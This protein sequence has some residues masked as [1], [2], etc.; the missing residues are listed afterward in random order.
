MDFLP[1]DVLQCICREWIGTNNIRD[2]VALDRAICKKSLRQKFLLSISS[3]P[4]SYRSLLFVPFTG[5]ILK[6][7]FQIFLKWMKVRGVVLDTL[8]LDEFVKEIPWTTLTRIKS[9]SLA[10]NQN[11]VNMLVILDNLPYLEDLQL[12]GE[13]KL[14]HI[15]W[16]N[17]SKPQREVLLLTKLFLNLDVMECEQMKNIFEYLGLHAKKLTKV[18]LF[19]NNEHA[20]E[21]LYC[22]QYITTLV[23]LD[24]MNAFEERNPNSSRIAKLLQVTENMVF[25]SLR[26]LTYY[27][28]ESFLFPF[29][30]KIGT[31]L[32]TLWW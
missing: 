26:I 24:F 6:S 25:P 5:K 2:F 27:G 9:L 18:H 10:L 1:T 7:N 3:C 20:D 22:L 32:R 23:D 29:L 28:P 30:S 15:S 19:I 11:T 8:R 14:T 17:R 21:L 31:T 13:G 16:E 12:R 4:M